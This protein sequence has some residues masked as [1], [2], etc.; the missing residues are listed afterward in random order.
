[1]IAGLER[2][3][4]P[5]QDG[6]AHDA[7]RIAL[8]PLAAPYAAFADSPDAR[9]VQGALALDTLV[10][11][12]AGND[13]PA[14]PGYGDLSSPG[15]APA[16]LTVGAADLRPR[17]EELRV[18]LRVGLNVVVDRVLPLA[19]AVVPSHAREFA[20]APVARRS[21]AGQ[22]MPGGLTPAPSLA[23]FFDS[24]GVSLVAG[25]AALVPA[26]DDPVT[27]AENAARAG[28]AAVALYG[29][30]LPAGGLGLDETVPVP[31]VSVPD[32]AAREAVEAIKRGE[33][34]G[35]SIGVPR[36]VRN[37]GVSA[38]APFSS[39]G[40]AFDGRVKPDLVAPGVA[41]M[42]SDPGS[43]DDGTPN[44]GTVNGSSAAA[45]I[46]AGAAALVAQARPDLGARALRSLLAGFTRPLAE[47]PV[48]AQGS[49]LLDVGAAAAGEF[50]ADPTTLAFG[51]AGRPNWRSEQTVVLTSFSTRPLHLFVRP[52]QGGG[53]GLSI[54]PRP[55]RLWLMPGRSATIRLTARI[56]GSPGNPSPAEG[57]IAIAEPA[58]APL[59]IPWTITFGRPP[60]P[61]LN[62]VRLS[63]ARFTP[64]DTAPA[65]LS[66][67]A[68]DLVA[69]PEAQQVEPLA[70]L[71]VG[72][73][74]A[75]G[76]S[77]GLLARLRDL[78]PGHYTIG[79][80][81]RDPDGNTLPPGDYELQLTAVPPD[82]G[83][84]TRRTIG[85]TIE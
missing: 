20:V 68:G 78:L 14:G 51:R 38:V 9:A 70:R 35:L 17:T 31:V 42:T 77:L 52:V 10:V 80:T 84:P 56:R 41:L 37:G 39:R 21:R 15:A 29:T 58:A 60:V 23:D 50:G 71:D 44:Y 73:T 63:E 18:V 75:A 8:V 12:P 22:A 54:V 7:A 34:P 55:S 76:T 19:G 67:V 11:A 81:G 85:F 2:A 6:D 43:S 4:D 16:A 65:V 32:D 33:Q 27:A 69:G 79:L 49:G 66:F 36:L 13:G 59:R 64:S 45:A 40:L 1:V 48:T 28:A 46:V 3:V 47:A 83:R 72:L 26:G 57:T 30:P 25:R 5:N 74:T 24:H 82:N 53:A 62:A 61:L